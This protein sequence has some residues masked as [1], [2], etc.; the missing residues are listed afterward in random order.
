LHSINLLLSVLCNLEFAHL[1]YTQAFKMEKGK[2][3]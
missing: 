2:Q 1:I 3:G